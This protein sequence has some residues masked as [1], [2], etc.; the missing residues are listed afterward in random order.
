MCF[1][2][3][4]HAQIKKDSK[5]AGEIVT[6]ADEDRIFTMVE[7]EAQFPGGNDGWR[8]YLIA[9][10]DANTPIKHR[11]RKGKYQV[12]IRFIVNKEGVL[13]NVTAETSYGHGMEEEAIRV[14]KNGPKWLPAMQNGKKVNAYR[15]Q[16]ITFV[17]E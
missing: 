7:E 3:C 13:S 5:D 12:V 11:A 6:A 16:P 15:R 2:F 14:I 4:S 8:K 1:S 17:V 9:N 10:I